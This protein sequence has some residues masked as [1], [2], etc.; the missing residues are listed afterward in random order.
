MLYAVTE[1]PLFAVY[2]RESGFEARE[3][4]DIKKSSLFDFQPD[5]L[6]FPGPI[7]PGCECMPLDSNCG[8]VLHVLHS[9]AAVASTSSCIPSGLKADSTLPENL[10]GHRSSAE[11]PSVPQT[12]FYSLTTQA[13]SWP[14]ARALQHLGPLAVSLLFASYLD[15]PS[16]LQL[17][18]CLVSHLAKTN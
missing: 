6:T 12:S 17:L 7:K 11:L 1:I 5:Y 3:T 8:T 18:F 14:P 2:S 13:C 16:I 15:L 4:W 9:Y 10:P